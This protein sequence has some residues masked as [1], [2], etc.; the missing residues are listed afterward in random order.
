MSVVNSEARGSPALGVVYL[1]EHRRSDEPFIL[2]A[3]QRDEAQASTVARFRQEAEAW[4]K[5][6]THSNVVRCF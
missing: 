4:V 5:L 6:G 2:K 1:V 3:F